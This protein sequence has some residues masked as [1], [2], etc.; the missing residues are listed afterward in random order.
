MATSSSAAPAT[1]ASVDDGANG[2]TATHR[3]TRPH[4]QGTR[5]D[6]FASNTWAHCKMT[7]L[8]RSRAAGVSSV[9]S[10]LSCGAVTCHEPAASSGSDIADDGT[11]VTEECPIEY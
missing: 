10:E 11:M 9:S 2:S 6:H 7:R 5:C 8:I 1:V 3:R 4:E